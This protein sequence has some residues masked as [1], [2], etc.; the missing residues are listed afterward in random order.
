MASSEFG[1][2]PANIPIYS[3]PSPAPISSQTKV[4]T[5][6]CQLLRQSLAAMRFVLPILAL[7]ASAATATSNPAALN[8]ESSEFQRA[9]WY[10]ICMEDRGNDVY[11]SEKLQEIMTAQPAPE[12]R[13]LDTATDTVVDLVVLNILGAAIGQDATAILDAR[14][15]PLLSLGGI[16]AALPFDIPPSPLA[17]WVM[18]TAST[19][20][21]MMKKTFG[22]YRK[23]HRKTHPEG[24][25]AGRIMG[26]HRPEMQRVIVYDRRYLE[27]TD[28]AQKAQQA[29]E[30][31][32]VAFETDMFSLLDT[33]SLR[34]N[35]SL[36]DIVVSLKAGVRDLL[37]ISAAGHDE[38]TIRREIESTMLKIQAGKDDLARLVDAGEV[39]TAKV[40]GSL[41]ALRPTLV[42]IHKKLHDFIAASEAI[43]EICKEPRP[44]S[45]DE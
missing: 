16:I 3:R 2:S 10:D 17:Q 27:W 43:E 26:L 20:W 18:G 7:R 11:C 34:A 45:P 32:R 12:E 21:G 38:P 5:T 25:S 35:A 30:R 41:K 39:D 23:Y 36:G 4:L 15:L 44:N 8:P 40:N 29:I 24:P 1:L 14:G 42:D 13:L 33:G 37:A 31:D 19:V 28:Q 22:I 6:P 9:L